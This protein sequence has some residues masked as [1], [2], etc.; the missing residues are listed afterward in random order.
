M[1]KGS[2]SG[3]NGG[4][5]LGAMAGS[6]GGMFSGTICDSTDDTFFCKLT[7]FTQEVRMF[8]FLILLVVM[9]IYY[10][11]LYKKRRKFLK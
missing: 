4:F 1:S 2:G 8:L 11:H 6:G 5:M 7:R 10:L 3:S 9:P